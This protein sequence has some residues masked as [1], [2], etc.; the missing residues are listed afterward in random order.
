[1][2]APDGKNCQRRRSSDGRSPSLRSR[3]RSTF[4][5]DSRKTERS[6]SR[7]RSTTRQRKPGQKGRNCPAASFRASHLPRSALA[8]KLYVSG[9]D[10]LLHRLNEAGDGWEV[11]GKLA[12]P[13]LTHR[14]LPG[15][16][17]DLLAVGGNFAGSP[18]RFVES[19]SIAGSRTQIR[20]SFPGRSRLIPRLVR[21]RPWA[22]PIDAHR[23]RRKPEHRASRVLRRRIS[24]ETRSRSRSGAWK[25]H[26]CRRFP[27][28]GN[29]QSSL[30]TE[31]AARAR[32]IFWAASAP[33]VMSHERWAMLSGSTPIARN[34]PS[35]QA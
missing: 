11:A 5:V 12:V 16:A 14:L 31:A 28:R 24:C 21:G 29:R 6:S 18:V 1:M 34:G 13:R 9:F 20:R 2:K 17:G 15:V 4:L 35:S 7:S 26:R 30:S 22:S 19:I 10:G 32:S 3:G 27:S 8:E 23:R 33:T 25:P